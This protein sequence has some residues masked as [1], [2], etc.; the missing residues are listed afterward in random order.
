MGY[1]EDFI[2]TEGTRVWRVNL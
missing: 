1:L 2:R